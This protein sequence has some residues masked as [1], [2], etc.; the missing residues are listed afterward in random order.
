MFQAFF[1][2]SAVGLVLLS[3]EHLGVPGTSLHRH[4]LRAK[5]TAFHLTW[6]RFLLAVK[7]AI[8]CDLQ[9]NPQNPRVL[10]SKSIFNRITSQFPLPITW[11][12]TFPISCVLF[13]WR[14]FQTGRTEGFLGGITAFLIM[15]KRNASDAAEASPQASDFP[16]FILAQAS[17]TLPE[18]PEYKDGWEIFGISILWRQV[19]RKECK[20]T[21]K[22]HLSLGLITS[23]HRI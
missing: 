5:S 10:P 8:S 7:I 17:A 9:R 19:R 13:W 23:S 2:C 22:A 4:P 6:T 3:L 16:L 20:A 1:T 11:Q 14:G 21:G 18:T 12:N 15:M